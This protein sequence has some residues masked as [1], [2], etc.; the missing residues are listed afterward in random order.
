M[1]C[2]V[3]PTWQNPSKSSQWSK[4]FDSNIGCPRS[5]SSGFGLTT[6]FSIGFRVAD[7][8][9]MWEVEPLNGTGFFQRSFAWQSTACLQ[10]Y[11]KSSGGISMRGLERQNDAQE[12]K[13]GHFS[14]CTSLVEEMTAVSMCGFHHLAAAVNRGCTW[15]CIAF[16]IAGTNMRFITN[17]RPAASSW[18]S[19]HLIYPNSQFDSNEFLGLRS[20]SHQDERCS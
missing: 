14:I 16:H 10:R 1:I 15:P 19:W 2:A 18:S 9:S 5:C 4:Q 11:C 13:V 6:L 8:G 20:W 12:S 17:W 3:Q 7:S